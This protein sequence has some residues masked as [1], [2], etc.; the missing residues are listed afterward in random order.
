M[1]GPACA[2]LSIYAK[3]K[4]RVSGFYEAI[5]GMSRIHRTA[6]VTVL[7]SPDIQFVVHRIPEERA[8][9]IVIAT[10]PELR[11]AALK[12]FFT[13]PSISEARSRARELGG[14]IAYEQWEG[15]CFTVCNG[16]DPEGNV[17]HV[18]E[19]AA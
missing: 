9:N 1:S 10:P 5:L 16:N 13:V 17:F 18:R 8:S 11:D 14:D 19:R 15:P 2:G 12:F 4:Q 3:D 7:Q 6:D